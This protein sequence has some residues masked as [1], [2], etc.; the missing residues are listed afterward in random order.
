MQDRT[1]VATFWDA[2]TH[3]M[4]RGH[5]SRNTG[6]QTDLRLQD[7]EIGGGKDALE[8]GE[9]GTHTSVEDFKNDIHTGLRVKLTKKN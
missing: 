6:G 2:C 3:G 5:L 9:P 8:L 7:E 4:D 1:Q